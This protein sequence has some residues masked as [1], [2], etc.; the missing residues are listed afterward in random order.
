MAASVEASEHDNATIRAVQPSEH[1]IEAMRVEF[2]RF[3][4]VNKSESGLSFA[5]DLALKIL[6]LGGQREY[7][8]HYHTVLGDTL[9]VPASWAATGERERIVILRHERVHLR[10]R[11]RY[12][13]VAFA[14]LYLVPWFPLGLAW[15]R[16]RLEWEAYAETLRATA[17][18]FGF[19]TLRDP[20]LRRKI[21]GRFTGPAYGWMW[22][23]TRQV[24]G[25]YDDVVG[26]LADAPRA[27]P[28]N[29]GDKDP[30]EARD[31]TWDRS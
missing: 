15:G 21:V 30:I 16:A 27:E 22:P 31:L 1:F 26:E 10:Q 18:L 20:D 2:P 24:E 25:W 6:T 14:F 23:F 9:Y 29:V 3:R 5:I 17:E 19:D 28:A 13:F 12:G 11:R 4:I 7:L 8:T